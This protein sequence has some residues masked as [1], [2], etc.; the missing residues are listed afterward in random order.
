MIFL[1]MIIKLFGVQEG[2]GLIF[3]FKTYM[4]PY[5]RISLLMHIHTDMTWCMDC[6]HITNKTKIKLMQRAL[7]V[8]YYYQKIL[9]QF[10]FLCV[11][12]NFIDAW[13]KIL[14]DN[15]AWRCCAY[16]DKMK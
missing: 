7:A 11:S 13:L 2:H 16:Q 14:A 10:F 1:L 8:E 5:L 12:I 3:F 15:F 6:T 9:Q 4:D